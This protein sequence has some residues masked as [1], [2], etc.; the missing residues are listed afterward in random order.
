[1]RSIAIQG[2]VLDYRR[3]SASVDLR[4]LLTWR[5]GDVAPPSE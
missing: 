4:V 5:G 2:T 1:M 3:F